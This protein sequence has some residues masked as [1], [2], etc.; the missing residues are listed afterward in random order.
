MHVNP[1]SLISTIV[2]LLLVSS[3]VLGQSSFFNFYYCRFRKGR[4]YISKDN[5]LSLISTIV[6]SQ[7]LI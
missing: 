7:S 2:D 4:I 6:D 5:P 3:E 1:L